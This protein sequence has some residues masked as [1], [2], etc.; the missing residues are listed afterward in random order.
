[1]FEIVQH[2]QN[3]RKESR[4]KTPLYSF[5]EDEKTEAET[6]SQPLWSS[7]FC[8]GA[9]STPE[10]PVTTM[11]MELHPDSLRTSFCFRPSINPWSHDAW[12]A[13][14]RGWPL[15]FCYCH[16]NAGV[17]LPTHLGI[18]SVLNQVFGANV[19]S[20]PDLVTPFT[21]LYPTTAPQMQ[22][23]RNIAKLFS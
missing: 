10:R 2:L 23:S 15:N 4:A 6:G 8:P 19:R 1:M 3:R 18:L 14:L 5:Y 7:P 22:G 21:T 9:T 16:P 11:R 13:D 20:N 17:C 12:L